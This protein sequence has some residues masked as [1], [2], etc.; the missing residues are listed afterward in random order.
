[1]D[2][3]EESEDS[4]QSTPFWFFSFTLLGDLSLKY[5]CL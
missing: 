1:M 5:V 4:V 2:L 3:D